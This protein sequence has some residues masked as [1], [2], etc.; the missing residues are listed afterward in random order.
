MKPVIVVVSIETDWGSEVL[1]V[2]ITREEW[3]S[4]SPDKQAALAKDT[5]EMTFFNACNYGYEVRS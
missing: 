4:A 2:E 5:A 1:E 3:D